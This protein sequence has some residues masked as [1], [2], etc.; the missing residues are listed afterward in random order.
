MSR[1]RS[2]PFSQS[3]SGAGAVNPPGGGAGAKAPQAPEVFARKA[4]GL[5][6]TASVFD[7]FSFNVLSGLI[8]ISS[9]FILSLVPAFYP[10]AN[11]WLATLFGGLEVLPLVLVY[12]RLSA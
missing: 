4:S 12:A 5:I 8:G 11:L 3:S 10:G 1:D 9:L 6:R 2:D 7:V